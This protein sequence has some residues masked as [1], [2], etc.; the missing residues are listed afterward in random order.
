ME[1]AMHLTSLDLIHSYGEEVVAGPVM[2]ALCLTRCHLAW[3][4]LGVAA[5]SLLL[6]SG[7]SLWSLLF[8]DSLF[9]KLLVCRW[10]AFKVLV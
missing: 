3:W 4:W 8:L 1:G 6:S 5:V 9:L 10:I 7:K 2:C